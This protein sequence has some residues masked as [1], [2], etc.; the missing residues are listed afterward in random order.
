M[1][2]LTSKDD[3]LFDDPGSL[4]LEELLNDVVADR[5]G[6]NDGEFRVSRHEVILFAMGGVIVL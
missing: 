4:V 2:Y 3:E 6:A 1:P 5:T